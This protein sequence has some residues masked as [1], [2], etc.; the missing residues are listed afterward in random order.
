MAL[1]NLNEN[2][3]YKPIELLSNKKIGIKPWK[4]KEEKNLLFTV[5]GIEKDE[6]AR[7][8]IVKFIKSLCDDE[9]IFNTLSKANVVYTLS[10]LRKQSKGTVIEYN[11]D[12]QKCQFPLTDEVNIEK[13]MTTQKFDS[14]PIKIGTELVFGIKEVSD[15]DTTNL[16]KKFVKNTEYNFN[17][18]IKSIDTIAHKGQVYEEFSEA[19]LIEFVDGMESLDFE[20]LCKKIIAAQ[21]DVSIEKTLTC[22]KCKHV[23]EIVFG[24][25]E[26]F[27]AF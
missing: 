3:F 16:R 24:E 9:K 19:E 21:A 20:E 11:Y 13:D 26:S 5:E 4:V 1:P 25:L 22:G 7:V 17:F 14:T 23:N 27:L 6:D 15:T 10:Q 2:V 8:E 12:C 18:I